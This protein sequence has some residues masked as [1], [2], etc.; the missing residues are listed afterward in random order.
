M[1][2]AVVMSLGLVEARVGFLVLGFDVVADP[3]FCLF[4]M[5][6]SATECSLCCSEW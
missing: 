5:A 1:V 4:Q 3:A 6:G 2:F